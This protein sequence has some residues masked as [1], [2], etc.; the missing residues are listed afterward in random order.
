MYPTK[1]TLTQ[2]SMALH[3]LQSPNGKN[4]T[5]QEDEER[6]RAQLG[7]SLG[8]KDQVLK[9]DSESFAHHSQNAF[10]NHVHINEALQRERHGCIDGFSRAPMKESER[11]ESNE[12]EPGFA[13]REPY[14]VKC[15]SVAVDSSLIP[16]TLTVARHPSAELAHSTISEASSRPLSET[17]H[18]RIKVESGLLGVLPKSLRI[19]DHSS[20]CAVFAIV[21]EESG[22]VVWRFVKDYEQIRHFYNSVRYK[23]DYLIKSKAVH[24]TKMPDKEFFMSNIPWQVDVRNDMINA[25]FTCIAKLRTNKYFMKDTAAQTT[26]NSILTTF[27]LQDIVDLH[28]PGHPHIDEMCGFLLVQ[29]VRRSKD[30]KTHYCVLNGAF[31]D[32]YHRFG[33]RFAKKSIPLHGAQIQ[34]YIVLF[35]ADDYNDERYVFKVFE[36][37]EVSLIEHKFTAE[38]DELRSRWIAHLRER[39]AEIGSGYLYPQA[40]AFQDS[41]YPS[42]YF[43]RGAINSNLSKSYVNTKGPDSIRSSASSVITMGFDRDAVNF[44]NPNESTDLLNR[45][46]V[47]DTLHRIRSTSD[48]HISYDPENLCVGTAQPVSCQHYPVKCL[49]LN[50]GINDQLEQK[51]NLRGISRPH[52]IRTRSSE[53]LN[54]TVK[55]K[56]SSSVPITDRSSNRLSLFIHPSIAVSNTRVGDTAKG[57]TFGVMPSKCKHL[58]KLK[59]G[60]TAPSVVVRCIQRLEQPGATAELGIFRISGTQTRLHNLQSEFDINGDY[61]MVKAKVD[62]HT[63]ADLLKRYLRSLPSPLFSEWNESKS[64][65]LLSQDDVSQQQILQIELKEMEPMHRTVVSVILSLLDKVR[66]NEAVN[67]M[68]LWNLGVAL[69]PAFN[70]PSP[71]LALYIKHV[72]STKL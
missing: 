2:I 17:I 63:T 8:S 72:G 25:I 65:A 62:V 48:S 64:K 54:L 59:S 61:D 19:S 1:P 24:L 6:F 28:P 47:Y 16:S 57:M 67:S 50:N 7:P 43:L 53:S 51:R 45:F 9:M 27:W 40:R 41:S 70:I 20:P 26:I 68:G 30:W 66:R 22:G 71:I 23:L 33:D 46:S 60:Q 58:L 36:K 49:D 4:L 55:R 44:K 32:V 10:S 34:R 52:S 29:P 39:V 69:S 31:L 11:Y 42:P 18:Y 14:V 56:I 38:S 37:C 12:L 3:V 21:D 35:D 5:P 13:I 15:P